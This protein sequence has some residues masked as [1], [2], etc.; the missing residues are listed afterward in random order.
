MVRLG[1]CESVSI[2]FIF[3]GDSETIEG[4]WCC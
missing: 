3:T 4:L 2:I 1:V